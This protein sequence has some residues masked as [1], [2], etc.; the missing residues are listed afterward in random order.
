MDQNRQPQLDTLQEKISSCTRCVV[1]GYLTE[2]NP[3]F[4]GRAGNR[5]MLIGQAPGPRAHLSGVPWAAA[6]GTVLRKWF[7]RAGFEPE[8]FLDDWYFTSVTKC[9]PGKASSGSGDRM[10]SA[11]ER[12]LC[13]PHLDAEIHLVQPHLIVTL[14]RMAIESILPESK[15]LALKD[16]VGTFHM[17]DLGYGAVPVIPLPHPSGVGRWLND[18]VNRTLVESA[19]VHLN[20]LR[21]DV[22]NRSDHSQLTLAG[23]PIAGLSISQKWGQ[24]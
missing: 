13:R 18:P 4:R 5:N 10:P 24:S 7:A 12:G 19:M 17:V 6:S 3:I 21:Q 14:G 22:S 15:P 9:F 8:R 1:A 20:R 16:L 23:Q 2:A 11:A